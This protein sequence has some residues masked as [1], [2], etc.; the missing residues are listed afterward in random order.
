M[1]TG[2]AQIVDALQGNFTS[3][4][5]FLDNPEEFIKNY[6]LTP[7]EVSALLNRDFNQLAELCGSEQLALGVVSGAHSSG[8]SG[9]KTTRV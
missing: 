4:V 2:F 9:N 5:M 3:V 1:S 7:L 6:N 8:C